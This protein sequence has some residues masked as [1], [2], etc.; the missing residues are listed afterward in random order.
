MKSLVPK[1]TRAV[2]MLSKI[3]HFVDYKTLKNIYY[4]LFQSHLIYGLQIWVTCNKKISDSV[5]RIQNKALRI[6]NFKQHTD[7]CFPLY[8]NSKIL[9]FPDYATMLNCLFINDL[10]EKT[11]PDVFT[12]FALPFANIHSHNT[13]I[14]NNK[15]F[16]FA[17]WLFVSCF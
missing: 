1:L 17:P 11:L 16:L 7:S 12:D 6:I 3:R 5:Q 15:L 8:L 14:A 4:A 13:R 9:K 2:G 10:F